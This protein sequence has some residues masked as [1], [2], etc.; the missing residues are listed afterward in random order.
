MLSPAVT[1]VQERVLISFWRRFGKTD[2]KIAL[3]RHWADHQRWGGRTTRGEFEEAG[4]AFRRWCAVCR[5]VGHHRHHIIQLR[6][7][8][9]SIQANTITL[10]RNCHGLVHESQKRFI[11]RLKLRMLQYPRLVKKARVTLADDA[12]AVPL[13]TAR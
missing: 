5:N 13:Q 11:D 12:G 3:L 2:D 6:Y 8:G 7:G 10:C 1:L 4:I 9:Q